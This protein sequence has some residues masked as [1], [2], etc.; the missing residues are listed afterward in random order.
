[1]LVLEKL[2][3]DVVELVSEDVDE[4]KVCF[5]VV[6]ELV[7]GVELVVVSLDVVNLL[8]LVLEKGDDIKVELVIIVVIEVEL[9]L[10]KRFPE[11]LSVDVDGV[12]FVSVVVGFVVVIGVEIVL[13]MVVICFEVNSVVDDGLVFEERVVVAVFDDVLLEKTIVDAWFQQMNY[14]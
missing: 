14:Y 2:I 9:L 12:R 7:D 6:L 1:M 5:S 4:I 3:L 11:P 10:D 8:E 13:K